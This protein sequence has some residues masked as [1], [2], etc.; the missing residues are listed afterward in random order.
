[1]TSSG[2]SDGPKRATKLRYTVPFTSNVLDFRRGARGPHL[3]EHVVARRFEHGEV[4]DAARIVGHGERLHVPLQGRGFDDDLTGLDRLYARLADA[5]GD[6]AGEQR[7]ELAGRGGIRL[8]MR[9]TPY[10]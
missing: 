8:C 9:W 5:R 3:R 1:M 2:P 6:A 10:P 4:L 7:D